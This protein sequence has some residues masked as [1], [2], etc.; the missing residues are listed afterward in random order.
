MRKFPKFIALLILLLGT[1]P[2]LAAVCA[3][4]LAFTCEKMNN[5]TMSVVGKST[6]TASNDCC[7]DD[8][9]QG[10]MSDMNMAG[11]GGAG[12][13]TNSHHCPMDAV[14]SF[15][16]VGGGMPLYISVT[17]DF[18]RVYASPAFLFPASAD[19]SNNTKPPRD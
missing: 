13:D 12:S 7:H 14:C 9:Q 1:T 16:S 5:Q 17:P 19:I 6:A 10:D 8:A 15:A 3:T 11:V 2:T 18:S 4:Q